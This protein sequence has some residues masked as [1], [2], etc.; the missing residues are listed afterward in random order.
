MG[1]VVLYIEYRI[2]FPIDTGQITKVKCTVPEN[3]Y[4]AFSLFHHA[5]KAI[6]RDNQEKA[7]LRVIGGRKAK[8]PR[9]LRSC[10]M[11]PRVGQDRA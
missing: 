9:P 2:L 8:G 7:K 5:H 11:G 10:S 3:L 6:S 1:K 4:L